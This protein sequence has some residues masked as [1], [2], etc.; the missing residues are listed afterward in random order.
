MYIKLIGNVMTNVNLEYDD[1][2]FQY[3]ISCLLC[4]YHVS[5]SSFRSSH[6]RCSVRKGV[7]RN[8]AKFTGK[9]LCQS[10]FF[11]KVAGLRPASLSKQE[12]LEKGLST[13][14]CDISKNTF[15]TEYLRT[16]ASIHSFFRDQCC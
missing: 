15:F 16:A 6:W 11:N 8:F 10:L 14:F 1:I 2:Y 7:L 5:L 3:N 4:L 13:E 9:L 12:T